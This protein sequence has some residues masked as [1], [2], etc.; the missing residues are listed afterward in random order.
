MV[1]WLRYLRR[2]ITAILDLQLTSNDISDNV[3]GAKPSTDNIIDK[4]YYFVSNYW[5][6]GKYKSRL[7]ILR[8]YTWNC[9]SNHG[10]SFKSFNKITEWKKYTYDK[11][12]QQNIKMF[13]NA[14]LKIRDNFVSSSNN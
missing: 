3:A 10:K 8:S 9:S 14:W 5:Y 1:Q 2:Y 6:N 12:I 7:S 13:D 11:A 4:T